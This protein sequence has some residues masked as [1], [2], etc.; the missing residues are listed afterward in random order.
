MESSSRLA[1]TVKSMKAAYAKATCFVPIFRSTLPEVNQV[2]V[3]PPALRVFISADGRN[4][5]LVTCG[6][7]VGKFTHVRQPTSPTPLAEVDENVVEVACTDEQGKEMEVLLARRDRLIRESEY[8]RS[9]FSRWCEDGDVGTRISF[10][11]DAHLVGDFLRYCEGQLQL[12]GC[13]ESKLFDIMRFADRYMCQQLFDDALDAVLRKPLLMPTVRNLYELSR[14]IANPNLN[15]CVDYLGALLLPLMLD[16]GLAQQL[17]PVE[18]RRMEQQFST[19]DHQSSLIPESEFCRPA[20]NFVME[21]LKTLGSL[22]GQLDEETV[23]KEAMLEY[24]L[25][26]ENRL[27]KHRRQVMRPLD[28]GKDS[29]TGEDRSENKDAKLDDGSDNGN[30]NTEANKSRWESQV[31]AEDSVVELMEAELASINVSSEPPSECTTAKDAIGAINKSEIQSNMI[32]A[33]ARA[34]SSKPTPPFPSSTKATYSGFSAGSSTIAKQFH[35]EQLPSSSR[36][37]PPR[38]ERPRPWGD[39]RLPPTMSLAAIVADEAERAGSS[40]ENSP[41]VEGEQVRPAN[42]RARPKGWHKERCPTKLDEEAKG[43]K[44]IMAAEVASQN[45]AQRLNDSRLADIEIEEHA[46]AELAEVYEAEAESAGT[47]VTIS[48]ERQHANPS[49]PLWPARR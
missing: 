36:I 32:S 15:D 14:S 8:C 38:T 25:R 2:A 29:V 31:P 48:V 35:E 10:V 5:A 46:I 7:Y 11:D 17:T 49:D 21:L 37:V 33:S 24:V 18:L 4:K 34:S 1:R 9:F 20:G 3:L 28:V 22:F 45:E 13:C 30:A 23:F 42:I 40:R 26:E 41:S 19:F 47:S 39:F 27:P 43:M 12:N 6:I 16:L 44:E